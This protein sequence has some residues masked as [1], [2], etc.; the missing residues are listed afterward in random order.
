[1]NE[2]ETTTF[3]YG[4]IG[5]NDDNPSCG[6]YLDS[7]YELT[8]EEILN[9]GIYYVAIQGIR[10]QP[11]IFDISMECNTIPP[12]S[13]PSFLPTLQPSKSPTSS[14]TVPPKIPKSVITSLLFG[15]MGIA[16]FII[17]CY[18][19]HKWRRFR[20]EKQELD[21]KKKK[22]KLKN[23]VSTDSFESV[24]NEDEAFENEDDQELLSDNCDTTKHKNGK[25]NKKKRKD[26]KS[27]TIPR[28][29]MQSQPTKSRQN[30]S[31]QQHQHQHQLKPLSKRERS[32]RRQ[33][34]K[35]TGTSSLRGLA[36]LQA[37]AEDFGA[38][39]DINSEHSYHLE[40]L[41][42]NTIMNIEEARGDTVRGIKIQRIDGDA[43]L[44]SQLDGD[45]D[46]ISLVLA[47]AIQCCEDQNGLDIFQVSLS[48]LI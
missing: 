24:P 47:H 7:K 45:D 30:G 6:N 21:D 36:G 9:E 48:S 17:G 43:T 33:L 35:N 29:T 23:K 32:Q 40:N 27:I 19:L 11:G 2:Q 22:K 34:K 16:L 4:I 1:M 8:H 25:K 15:S 13:H 46:V 12:S 41:D 26:K 18:Y 10:N 14:P 3:E 28:A 38:E 37:I 20:K 39:T 31:R 5:Q 42:L 44:A